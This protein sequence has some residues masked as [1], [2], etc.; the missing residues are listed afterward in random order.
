[1]YGFTFLSFSQPNLNWLFKKKSSRRGREHGIS[2]VIKERAC[3]NSRGQ[4]KK[5]WNFQGHSRKTHAE[6]FP[7]V[8][9]FNLG[10]FKECHIILLN[11]QWWKFVFPGFSKGKV[12]NL[13]ILGGGDF[14]VKHILNPPCFDFIW[15]SPIMGVGSLCW[16]TQNQNVAN[17]TDC[18][19]SRKPNNKH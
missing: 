3:R 15:N 9:V 7:W 5:K 17:C 14:S 4:L 11:F 8:L 16:Q 1:M 10:I 13:K 2:R 6:E 19:K 18:Y 12:T